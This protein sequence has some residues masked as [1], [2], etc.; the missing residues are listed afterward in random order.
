MGALLGG[1]ARRD[2]WVWVGSSEN[3]QALDQV[4]NIRFPDSL[5]T[6]PAAATEG[7]RQANRRTRL[8]LG[9]GAAILAVLACGLP[10]P[11]TPKRGNGGCCVVAANATNGHVA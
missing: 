3:R 9:I 7:F 5:Q 8:I 4:M 11:C 10:G 2:A 1:F 6:I